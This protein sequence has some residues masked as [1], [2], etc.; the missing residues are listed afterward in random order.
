MLDY[1]ANFGQ[2]VVTVDVLEQNFI[3]SLNYLA[4]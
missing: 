4:F 1:W 2:I 3:L